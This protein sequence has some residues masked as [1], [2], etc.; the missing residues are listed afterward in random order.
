MRYQVIYA[1]PPWAYTN[2]RTGGSHTSGAAQKYSTLTP[3]E[4]AALPVS[5]L[6]QLPAT[7]WLWATVPLLPEILPVMAAWGF[8]YKTT[9]VWHKTGRRGMGYWFRGEAE[10]LLFGIRG[11]V[12]A[13]YSQQS[14]VIT[15]PVSTHSRKPDGVRQLIEGLTPGQSRLELFAREPSGPGWMRTG[16]DSDG[17]DVTTFMRGI[18][19]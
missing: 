10:L 2:K 6:V 3:A 13:F 15:T 9:L 4:V 7:L 5:R 11:N 8:T 18:G 1:D 12:R 17:Y 14:N 19:V 16:F